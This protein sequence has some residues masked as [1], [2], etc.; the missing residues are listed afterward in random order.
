MNR[1]N[2]IS[3]SATLSRQTTFLATISVFE[4]SRYQMTRS[5]IPW[6]DTAPINPERPL[7]HFFVREGL[8]SSIPRVLSVSI[9]NM[10][11]VLECLSN[12]S[13]VFMCWA[14]I[15]KWTAVRKVCTTIHLQ[16]AVH[17]TKGF[18]TNQR[19]WLVQFL[20]KGYWVPGSRSTHPRLCEYCLL[21]LGSWSW[22]SIFF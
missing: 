8:H 19:L 21:V 15:F 17:E 4:L 13:T 2:L 1:Y 5:L 9:L 11:L 6:S 18:R 20:W 10:N 22:S 3:R 7:Q 16:D 12:S 14:Y